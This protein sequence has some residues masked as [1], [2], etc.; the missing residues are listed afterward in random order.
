MKWTPEKVHEEAKKHVMMTWGATDPMMDAAMWLR[1]GEG[2]Y[3]IDDTGKR[4]LDWNAGAMCANLGHTVPQSIID[5]ITHQLKTL[6]YTY[7]GYGIAE[8]RAKLAAL[9]A[10]I[11]PG[12]INSFLFPSTGMEANETALRLA[13]AYT[14]RH[15]VLSRYRSYHGSSVATMGLTGDQRRWGAEAGATGNKHFF[16]PYPYGFKWGNTEEEVTANSLQYLRETVQMEGGHT[17]AAIIV[18]TVT[19]TNGILKAPKGY[20]EGVRQICDENGIVFIAD[21][22][23]AGFGRTGKWFGF[24]H[25][26]VMPD[27]FTGAKGLTA[28]Y[29]PLGVVGMNDKLAAHFHKNPT[30][31]GSTYNSHPVPLACGY[32]TMEYMLEHRIVQRVAALEPLMTTRLQRLMDRHASVKQA[33]CVGL[34]ACF[35]IQKNANGDF[36]RKVTDPLTDEM[37]KLKKKLMELGLFTMLRGH[38]VMCNPPLTISEDEI[39]R[40][41]DSIE[42]ALPIRDDAMQK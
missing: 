24:C 41:F 20:M 6:P 23:M 42:K 11:V 30:L 16:D 5:A 38:T 14:G 15:K 1:K 13:R 33:R 34:F 21:E 18:E 17:I 40:G 8:I 29:L 32:A 3:L 37:Y 7:P 36:N 19:G 10:D 26:D 22:V 27:M 25:Y 28:S 31:I 2:V 9:L 12:D 35:D 4:I 39:N